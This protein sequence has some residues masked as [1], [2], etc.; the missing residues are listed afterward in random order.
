MADNID[1][2]TGKPA[3]AYVGK[4]PWHGLGEQLPEGQPIE[5][6]L[7]AARLEWELLKLPVQYLVDGG[8]RIMDDRYVLVR[9][10]TQTGLS[11]VSGDYLI[12]QPKEVLEFYRDLVKEFGYTLET[13]GALD[14]G[15]KVWALARTNITDAADNEGYD[16]LG[17]YLLLATSCDKTLATTAAF[18]AIR[19]VCENTLFF[20]TEDAR[21]QRRLQVK[22]PH[23][24]RFDASDVKA[25]LGVM[26]T[27]WSGFMAR[28]RSMSAYQIK[29]EM[30]SSFFDALFMQKNSKALS[31]RAQRERDTIIS[32]YH[33]APGHELTSAN[34]TL[35]GAVN[36]VSYYV[37]HVR[38]GAAGERLDSAW[39]G[40]GQAL[41]EKAWIHASALVQ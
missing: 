10:D 1:Q 14:H 2:S 39:F 25:E 27:A 32:L 7:R 26:T 12:V 35:W 29:A 5:T 30:A 15:R 3:I 17:A 18:T 6:W 22:V 37:D 19:V 33:S 40:S 13:A 4:R 24:L 23:N 21:K 16:K 38:S 31:N 28:V 20:A 36:A 8:L 41:K 11:I 34:Q 9:S